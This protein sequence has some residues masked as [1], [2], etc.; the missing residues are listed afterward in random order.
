[1]DKTLTETVMHPDFSEK[2]LVQYTR[3]DCFLLAYY[4]HKKLGEE[5]QIYAIER[6][7]DDVPTLIHYLVYYRSK[8]T[9]VCGFYES[10][11]QILK[12]WHGERV[13]HV[14]EDRYEKYHSKNDH[15]R[16]EKFVEENLERI[17]CK[18]WVTEEYMNYIFSLDEPYNL[19]VSEITS[20]I[21]NGTFDL[22]KFLSIIE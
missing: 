7:D 21:L 11:D 6:K 5:S 15:S 1:M 3:G 2:E 4:L 22:K 10:Q 13:V 12:T 9:D 14:E 17:L 16:V 8:Y 19:D 18:G 20:S